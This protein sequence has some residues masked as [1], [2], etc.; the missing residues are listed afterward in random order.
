MSAPL[1]PITPEQ[2]VCFKM[3]LDAM[4]EIAA[5]LSPTIF[6]Y[7]SH[8]LVV[9]LEVRH[10]MKKKKKKNPGFITAGRMRIS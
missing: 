4:G 5:L 6:L 8:W 2:L 9:V 3:A 7:H 10:R 1:V